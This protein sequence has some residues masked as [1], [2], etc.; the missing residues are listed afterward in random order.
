MNNE[1]FK[2]ALAGLLH[3]VGKFAQRREVKVRSHTVVGSEI[4]A[5]VFEQI[6]PFN[7]QDDIGDVIRFHHS[8]NP[9]E[10]EKE[11]VKAVIVA[12]WLAS[13][14]RLDGHPEKIDP[15]NTPLLPITARVELDINQIEQN[16][17]FPLLPLSTKE[18]DIFPQSIGTIKVGED[19]Y[20]TLW[21]QFTEAMSSFPG[22]ID[23]YSRVTG[24][25]SLFRQFTTHIPS[26]TPWSRDD[27]K[28]TVPDVSLYDHLK[29]TA[30]IAPCLLNLYPDHLNELHRRGWR[31]MIEGEQR[32]VAQLI[33]GDLSGIQTFIYRITEPQR[34]GSHRSTAKRLRGRS[35]YLSM[36]T[37]VVAEW[38]LRKLDLTAAN[39]LFVGGGRFDLLVPVD[40]NTNDKID[41]L[42]QK[43]EKWL[44]DEF[45][46]AIGLVLATEKLIPEDFKDMQQVNFALD[47][48]LV[49]AKQK[50][51]SHN[52]LAGFF[53]E[54]SYLPDGDNRGQQVC[55]VCGL[56]VLPTG[57][58]HICDLC[59]QH[60]VIGTQLPK[61]KY[62][63][64]IYAPLSDI[65]RQSI[66]VPSSDKNFALI[67][68][69]RKWD[70][71]VF[72][73]LHTGVALL[74][75]DTN[76][77]RLLDDV[78]KS[79]LEATIYALND[80]PL[81]NANWPAHTA[82]ARM[83]LANTAPQHR[84]G[85]V[86]EF[87]SIAAL[88]TG[89]ALLGILK[90]DVD[91][92]G[93]IFSLGLEPP[94]ISRVAALSHQFDRFFSGY[95]NTLCRE[96]TDD[97]KE[98]LSDKDAIEHRAT[99]AGETK[100]DGT[101]NSVKLDNLDSLF[102][103]TY[104]GG[105][106]LLII[107]PW[108]Q[109]VELAQQLNEKFRAYTC[110]NPNVTLSAGI[111]LVKPHFPVQRFV[112]LA[113]EALGKAKNAGRNRITLFDQTAPWQN[114]QNQANL[115]ATGQTN[116]CGKQDA[117]PSSSPDFAGLKALADKLY[118]RLKAEEMPRTLI[119]DML[120]MRRVEINT[121]VAGRK[122][123]VTPQ[124]LYLLTRRL[125][126]A[127]RDDLKTDILNAWP[128]IQMPLSYVSL[129]TRKE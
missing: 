67:K 107:G 103:I 40:K 17:G 22:L 105:D 121:R 70:A 13:A 60:K 1:I 62:L 47:D 127:V 129:K 101:K 98:K 33:R 23:G 119:H 28:R 5:Q 85:D 89:T 117:S 118:D 122:P 97:W 48:K 8:K 31:K 108:D 4:F 36:L 75:K 45:D 128:T 52:L 68:L 9:N 90:A 116:C 55:D 76:V 80:E 37:E 72:E 49:E 2:A 83:Y 86:L 77:Q 110:C 125:P 64:R 16:W 21:R 29:V 50:K 93:L 95:L 123:M 20:Q 10:T 94:T 115:A 69:C 65:D 46:T 100:A 53:E 81:P 26:A 41:T 42:K 56:S 39:A 78:G 102:Y 61:T 11:I 126:V 14:E 44:V 6:I 7:W 92:L 30:A 106:D 57:N 32:P 59:E 113:D 43:L 63:A 79:G 18:G 25:M 38:F 54:K 3:D 82:P 87:E 12:D 71:I 66:P 15:K 111:A 34:D 73:S 24:L 112:E 120:Q 109:T 124:L 84:D 27:R 99:Q 114:G 35:F 104:A 19:P 91:H 74:D 51:F 96:V 88:S 58:N